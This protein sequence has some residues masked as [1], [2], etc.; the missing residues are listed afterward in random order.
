M[1]KKVLT[2]NGGSFN[3]ANKP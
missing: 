2:G 1:E 3:N